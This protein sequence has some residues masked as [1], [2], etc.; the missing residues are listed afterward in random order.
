VLLSLTDVFLVS[1]PTFGVFVNLLMLLFAWLHAVTTF[2]NLLFIQFWLVYFFSPQALMMELC[3]YGTWAHIKRSLC[4]QVTQ[5]V[6][7]QWRSK[8]AGNT[9]HQVK[10]SVFRQLTNPN[11]HVMKVYFCLEMSASWFVML[12]ELFAKCLQQVQAASKVVAIVFSHILVLYL[13]I[14]TDFKLTVNKQL[15]FDP[16]L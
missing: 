8:E 11:I 12:V 7:C 13:Q 10:K 16:K 14:W 5:A 9:W 3:V 1:I 15:Q 4:S 2:R 6:L